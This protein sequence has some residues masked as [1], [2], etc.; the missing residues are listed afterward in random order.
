MCRAEEETLEALEGEITPRCRR[1]G[2][3][4]ISA[5]SEE[6]LELQLQSYVK[7]SS[8]WTGTSCSICCEYYVVGWASK[9][10]GC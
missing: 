5:I 7:S 6:L 10:L 1:N 9:N 4:K 2:D 3:L 8:G